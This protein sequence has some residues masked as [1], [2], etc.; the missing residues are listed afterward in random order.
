MYC[1]SCSGWT[2]TCPIK[3]IADAYTLYQKA[4]EALAGLKAVRSDGRSNPPLESFR[5]YHDSKQF[6]S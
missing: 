3:R 2:L 1:D 4:D 6:E 5:S